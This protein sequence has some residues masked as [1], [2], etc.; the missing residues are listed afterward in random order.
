MT[1]SESK[2]TK[3]RL[4]GTV[5]ST[6]M[7][8]TAVVKVDRTMVHPKYGKRYTVSQRFKAHDEEGKAVLGAEVVIE[9]TRPYSKDKRWRLVNEQK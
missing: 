1:T 9:E 3:R 4:I 6:K 8:K 7:A 5:V 2:K